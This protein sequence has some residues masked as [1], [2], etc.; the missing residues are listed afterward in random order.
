NVLGGAAEAGK[1]QELDPNANVVW[2]YVYSDANHLSH[3]DFCPLPN[4]NVILTAW[5]VRT[6]S[7]M[8]QAGSTGSDESWPTHFVELEPDGAGSATIVWEWHI[9]DHLIQDNDSTKD[10]FG[11]IADHPELMDINAVPMFAFF[12]GEGDW[13]H[14]NGISYN[15]TLDQLVFSSRQASEFYIIDH[16]T[17]TAEAATA[18]GGNSGM[19][20][21][22]LYRW[23]NPS[24][25]GAPG[26]QEIPAATHDPR[27]IPAGRPYAGYIQF[28]NNEGV[29][30]NQ[31]TVDLILPPETG[32]TYSFTAGSSYAP[33]AYSKRH[34]T[35]VSSSGQSASD[36]MSNGNIFVSVSGEYMYEVDSND[37]MIWQYNAGPGKAFR[38]ECDHPGLT[39]LL[40]AD[41]CNLV[42]LNEISIPN[43]SIYPNPSAGVFNIQG[44][45]LNND[46]EIL[47]YD[48]FGKLILSAANT[49]T[50][51]LQNKPV[52]MY[53]ANIMVNGKR[54]M[55]KMVIIEE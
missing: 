45:D 8:V 52:G 4:G 6:G 30:A 17:T 14:V 55:T 51:T 46:I 1:I 22:F 27:W 24:N 54:V 2:E 3:H 21:D 16:S 41:P 19:G 20:G 37:N 25:Y 18:A 44:L 48:V 38:Y 23:G 36:R 15:E 29:S 34:V 26:T 28:W 49:D 32:N 10:N 33:T 40:G 50:F 39:A 43:I 11:V 9:W 5:E 12:P 53:M 42:G 7:E 35:L 13:F 47:V 31:S